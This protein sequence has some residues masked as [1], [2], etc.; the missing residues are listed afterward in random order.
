MD[1]NKTSSV[2]RK[3]PAQHIHHNPFL[4]LCCRLGIQACTKSSR[5]PALNGND[6]TNSTANVRLG[7]GVAESLRGPS[8]GLHRPDNCL[9]VEH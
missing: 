9:E 4:T 8:L 3:K 1:G 7:R 5:H 6:A 2:R